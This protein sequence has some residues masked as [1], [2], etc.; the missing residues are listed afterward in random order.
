M[1]QR[2]ELRGP[3]GAELAVGELLRAGGVAE[4]DKAVVALHVVE[5][6]AVKLAGEP[7][8]QSQRP[9]T[10]N[11]PST[12]VARPLAANTPVTRL[13]GRAMISPAP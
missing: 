3:V 7:E 4:P 2:L 10:W 11:P 6:G 9:V 12:L 5:A 13:S 1:H 8:P